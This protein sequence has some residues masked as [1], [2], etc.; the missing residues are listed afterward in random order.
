MNER[1]KYIKK[2]DKAVIAVQLNLDFDGFS[3]RKWG[4]DQLCRAGDWLVDNNGDVYTVDQE[5]FRNT[6][7]QVSPGNYVKVKP[8]WA[9]VARDSG[10]VDTIEGKTD[11]EAG[12][13][14]VAESEDGPLAYCI[15]PAKFESM[16]ERTE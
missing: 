9:E 2:A 14:L 15:T 7:R 11:Y 12:D 8:I 13:Y 6:Y 5:V 3:Y 1:K 16:Y 10:A 4:N